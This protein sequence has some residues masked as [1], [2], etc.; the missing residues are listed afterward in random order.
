VTEN[1]WNV[2]QKQFVLA[3]RVAAY[4]TIVSKQFSA[5]YFYDIKIQFSFSASFKLR[6]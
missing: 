5:H 6:Y 3:D 4:T 1:G 2:L